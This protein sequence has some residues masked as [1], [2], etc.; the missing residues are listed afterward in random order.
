MYYVY[1]VRCSDNSLYIG[2]TNDIEKRMYAHIFKLKEAARYTKSR[3]VVELVSL[4]ITPSRS[5]GSKLEYR[6]K[7]LSKQEKETLILNPIID[8]AES[9]KIKPE[10]FEEIYLKR[11][12]TLVKND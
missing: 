9:I 1:I 4:W 11:K 2:I 5:E 12:N 8:G 7:Q 6:L 3:E 10:Y